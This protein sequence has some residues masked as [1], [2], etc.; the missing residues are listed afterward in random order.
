MA[1]GPEYV[2]GLQ[3]ALNGRLPWR[4]SKIEGGESWV[5][6]RV[7]GVGGALEKSEEWFLISWGAGSAGCCLVDAASVDALRRGAPARMP[8]VEALKSRFSKGQIVSARQVNFDRVLELEVVRFVAAGFGVKYYLTLEITEPVGN[9]VLLDGERRIEELAR[10]AS[11]DVNRLRTLLPGHLYVPPPVFEGPLPREIE[12]L[13][14]E[15]VSGVRGIGRPL[16]RLIDA[17]WEERGPERWLA[18]L[19]RLYA[20]DSLPCCRT[21]KGYFTRFPHPFGETESLG[22]DAL[23]A[24]REGVLRPLLAGSRSRLMRELNACLE[25]AAKS[26][27]RHLDGLLK[28]LRDNADAEIFRRK[29][30]L[31][32]ASVAAIPPRAEK[33]VLSGWDGGEAL[34]I[35]LDPRLSPSR[36]AERYF[37]KCRKARV[38]PQKIREEVDSLTG[39]IA[40]LR[41]QKDL[42]DSIDDPAKLEEAVRDVED[43]IASQGRKGAKEESGSA[44][45]RGK[46]GAKRGSRGQYGSKDKRGSKDKLPPHLRFEIDGHTVLVGLS[47]RGN[48]FVTF[49]QA[50]GDDLWLHAHEVP[51]A[52]VIVK[53]GAG[54]RGELEEAGK[55]LLAFAASL[56]AAYSKG[57]TSLS[58]QVDYTERRHVR[59]VPG[60]AVALV[61]YTNP[62][63]I[64]V[65]PNF[66]RE[67]STREAGTDTPEAPEAE[68]R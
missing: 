22:E 28:Q 12:E 1:F 2:Y 19:R 47:A 7:S 3:V 33:V 63:T 53:G 51:G 13:T 60:A 41:E 37:K 54:G 38:D 18:A 49:R 29:G 56:A 6:L 36:N 50:T 31:L 15:R 66:W 4:V 39:A 34:E 10:H 43:W 45:K 30:E 5:A 64:R 25:R 26:K 16:A 40:E 68:D 8:L 35:T 20:E 14:F 67:Y 24:A 23:A 61:T 32:L 21:V 52:H 62:G 65:S 44:K 11:P 55:N 9:V 17:H 48:R 59:S 58:V 27:E 57:R 42:L 46:P